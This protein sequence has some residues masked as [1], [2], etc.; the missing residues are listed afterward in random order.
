VLQSLATDLISAD[1]CGADFD[2]QNPLVMQA[3]AGLIAYEPVYRA[4]CLRDP[5][6]GS[7]CFSEAITN[8]SAASD[9]YPYYT[10]LGLVM[11][12]GSRPTCSHCL[13]NTMAIFATYAGNSSQPLSTT[14][15]SCAE[16]IDAGCGAGF[17]NTTA[18]AVANGGA[19]ALGGSTLFTSV[20]A[21]GLAVA[22]LV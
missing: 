19:A 2:Q 5:M 18:A 17:V 1:N 6:T 11:P 12:K 3:Y 20:V 16:Q 13:Q 22:V 4:T 9:A 7:Y 10:A 14:Y 21:L 8:A 15:T